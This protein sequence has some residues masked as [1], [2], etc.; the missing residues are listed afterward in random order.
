V[1]LRFDRIDA[2][3]HTLCHELSHVL[4]GDGW[5]IDDNLISTERIGTED[6][7]VEEQR[8]DEEASNIL[9]PRAKLESFIVRHRPRF[10]KV[11]II[12]FANLHQ[13]HP[14]IVVGQLQHRKAIRFSHSREM[15]VPIRQLLTDVAFTDGWGHF[16]SA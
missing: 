11:N 2:F 4:H 7:G 14:G 9:V 8:A 6:R 15:L 1:S 13:I 10:S 16:P 5:A 3:W 12:R